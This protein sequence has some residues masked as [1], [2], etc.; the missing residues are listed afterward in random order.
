MFHFLLVGNH[1]HSCPRKHVRR[2][3]Q[4]R[5]T[6][7]VNKFKNIVHACQFSPT[8]LVNAKFVA[9]FG[10]FISIFRAVNVEWR[11]SQNR[12]ILVVKP[13]CQVVRNLTACG[14]HYS[15][16]IFQIN[17]VE[18]AFQR[19]F[20]EIE[21]VAGIVVSRDGFRVV[22][23]HYGA[24]AFFFDCVQRIDAAPV[25][26]HRRTNAVSSRSKH[27]HRFFVVCKRNV[28]RCS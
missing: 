11:R 3:N 15:V 13:H 17:Y 22:V 7:F 23:D 10:E 8:R 28:M 9:H 26:F 18:H 5:E 27:N 1:V 24:V 25:K 14:N 20:V 6:N 4:H 2:T 21:A 16:W 19:E 12:H